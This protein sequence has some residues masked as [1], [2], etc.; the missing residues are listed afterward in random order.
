PLWKDDRRS[1][2]AR[3]AP[4]LLPSLLVSML[5]ATPTGRC[6]DCVRRWTGLQSWPVGAT[7]TVRRKVG[8]TCTE[9]R[10]TSVHP[11]G[12]SPEREPNRPPSARWER[13]IMSPWTKDKG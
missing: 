2:R 7:Y 5:S 11:S 4:L 1:S 3:E 12:G 6:R 13:A 9:V 8:S 10:G